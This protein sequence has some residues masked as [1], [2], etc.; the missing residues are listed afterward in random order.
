LSKY[1]QGYLQ[2]SLLSKIADSSFQNF[3]DLVDIIRQLSIDC[4]QREGGPAK[5]MLLDYHARKL[6]D[7]RQYMISPKQ[8][9]LQ[10]YTYLCDSQSKEFYHKAMAAALWEHLGDLASA[11]FSPGT[12]GTG[13]GSE[14][15][16]RHCTS[17]ELHCLANVPGQ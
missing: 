4:P 13:D 2:A 11:N 7:I 9:I 1:S 14:T 15:R 12:N 16:C 17:K 10:V 3:F 8:L 5:V 6:W